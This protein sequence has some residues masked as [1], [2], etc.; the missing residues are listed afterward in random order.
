[1]LH[2]RLPVVTAGEPRALLSSVGTLMLLMARGCHAV[3]GLVSC[4]RLWD[5]LGKC[6]GVRAKCATVE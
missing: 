5:L 3:C 6:K 1:M 2:A 4:W